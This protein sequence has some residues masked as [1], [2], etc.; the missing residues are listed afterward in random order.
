MISKDSTIDISLYCMLTKDPFKLA[1]VKEINPNPTII[2]SLQ[3][4][5]NK[6]E[7]LSLVE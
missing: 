1:T 3:D 2:A 4:K 6:I 7:K 5:V